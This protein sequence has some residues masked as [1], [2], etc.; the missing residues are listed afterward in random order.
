MLM[1]IFP[2]LPSHVIPFI[3][4]KDSLVVPFQPKLAMT[5]LC[6]GYYTGEWYIYT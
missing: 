2:N 3:Y 5:P 4:I 6:P 1:F